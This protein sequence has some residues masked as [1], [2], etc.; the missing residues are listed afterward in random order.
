MS[1]GLTS[2]PEIWALR[3][4]DDRDSPRHAIGQERVGMSKVSSTL[5]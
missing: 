1:V 2:S 3:T 5:R 4:R